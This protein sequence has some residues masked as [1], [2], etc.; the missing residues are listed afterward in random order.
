[1]KRWLI[2]FFLAAFLS[3]TDQLFS[4]ELMLHKHFKIIVAFF[5]IQTFVFFRLETLA[6][7]EWGV[8][9]SLGIIVLRFLSSAV[10]ILIMMLSDNNHFQLV[11]QFLILY[12]IFMVFEIANSLTKLRR[13]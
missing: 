7:K 10:F 13:N 2:L 12:L 6:P 9:L 4:S 3:L 8:H 5:T 11:V 1:M